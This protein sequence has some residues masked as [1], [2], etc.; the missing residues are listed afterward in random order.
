MLKY[1]YKVSPVGYLTHDARIKNLVSSKPTCLG[2]WDD[3]NTI[4]INYEQNF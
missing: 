1:P 2:L 4:I 3:P